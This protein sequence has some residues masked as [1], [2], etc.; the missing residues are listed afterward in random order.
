[1]TSSLTAWARR[2]RRDG[3]CDDC[4]RGRSH[5]NTCLCPRGSDPED[6][7]HSYVRIPP[8]RPRTTALIALG[9][10]R[11][12]GWAQGGSCPYLNDGDCDDC[13]RGRSHGNTCLCPAGSDP[14]DCGGFGGGLFGGGGG[15]YCACRGAHTHRCYTYDCGRTCSNSPCRHGF[16]ASLGIFENEENEPVNLPPAE[17]L[18]HILHVSSTLLTS[19]VS[20]AAGVRHDRCPRDAHRRDRRGGDPSPPR[21]LGPARAPAARPC[22]LQ[23]PSSTLL[24]D[25]S[26]FV[27]PL[28]APPPPRR[29]FRSSSDQPSPR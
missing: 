2:W 15:G 17:N 25:I 19:H 27:R 26:F 23:T 8:M 11:V 7:G 29:P 4:S 18:L 6:C 20:S 3:D 16:S 13:S 9:S 10:P 28:D 24:T 12:C 1:M 22:V 21:G 5:G 14:G